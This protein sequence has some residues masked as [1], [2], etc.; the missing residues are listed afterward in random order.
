[1]KKYIIVFIICSLCVVNT[2][3]QKWFNGKEMQKFSSISISTDPNENFKSSR[4]NI[5]IE[6]ERSYEKYYARIE[7]RYVDHSEYSY[8]D[9][10]LGAGI[11]FSFFKHK[12]D[13]FYLGIR[14]GAIYRKSNIYETVGIEA[15]INWRLGKK[16]IIGVRTTVDN[17]TDMKLWNAPSKFVNSNYI[18]LGIVL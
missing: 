1:M 14:A 17:R 7:A 8:T 9:V 6:Y 11:H 2:Y 12:R 18:K 10:S 16:M 15:G 4:K 3:G 5:A 13:A